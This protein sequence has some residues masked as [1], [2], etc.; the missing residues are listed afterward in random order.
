MSEC[1]CEHKRKRFLSCFDRTHLAS[2]LDELPLPR[3]QVE[4]GEVVEVVAVVPLPAVPA[5]HKEPLLHQARRVGTA[6]GRAV[7]PRLQEASIRVWRSEL[8]Q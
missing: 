2:R 3:D 4:G 7:P 8:A 5:E 1:K 6:R